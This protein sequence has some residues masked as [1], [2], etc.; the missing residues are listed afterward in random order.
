[1]FFCDQKDSYFFCY[2]VTQ[3]CS[4]SS[5][6]YNSSTKGLLSRFSAHKE[7][8][9]STFLPVLFINSLLYQFRVISSCSLYIPWHQT[10]SKSRNSMRRSLRVASSS[11][12]PCTKAHHIDVVGQFQ[13]PKD[14]IWYGDLP[15]LNTHIVLQFFSHGL[16]QLYQVY[17]GEVQ[18]PRGGGYFSDLVGVFGKVPISDQNM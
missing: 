7:I 10:G 13:L 4:S 3:S 18:F 6:V 11:R 12:S 2:I 16:W 8:F 9:L 14:V 17:R 5:V 15:K 1:M